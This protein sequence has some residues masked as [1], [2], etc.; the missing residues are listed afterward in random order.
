MKVLTKIIKWLA[1]TI[2][3]ILLLVAAVIGIAVWILTPERL[4]PLVE[5][6]ASEYLDAEVAVKRVELTYWSSFPKLTV[7][8]DS[9]VIVSHVF[10]RLTPAQ[11]DSLPDDADKLLSLAGL[12]GSVDL[13]SLMKGMLELRDIELQHPEIRLI[14][15]DKSLS[16][17]MIVK[18]GD[19]SDSSGPMPAI[20]IN[21]FRITGDSPISYF[22]LS[23][24]IDVTIKL[25][26]TD[27]NGEDAPVYSIQVD[28][29]GTGKIANLVHM[30]GIPFGLNG[31]VRWDMADPDRL[32]ISDFDFSADNI[33]VR[34]NGQID[35]SDSLA[36]TGLEIYGS[37]VKI[38]NLLSLARKT[39]L[40]GIPEI[41]TNLE[42]ELRATLG[43]PYYFGSDS[44]PDIHAEIRIPEGY[45]HYD[46]LRINRFAAD[47]TADI[48]RGDPDHARIEI[49]KLK[50]VGR[51]MGFNLS[52][53]VTSTGDISNPLV[54]GR[55]EGGLGFGRIPRKLADRLPCTLAGY[56]TGDT[57]FRFRPSDLRNV[58]LNAIKLDGTV[59]LHDF[60]MTMRDSSAT[61]FVSNAKLSFGAN[62]RLRRE[63]FVIDSL[64]TAS[65]QVDSADYTSGG[66]NFNGRDLFIGVGARHS[67]NRRLSG[68]TTRILPVGM[69][70]SGKRLTM[71]DT[72]D[73]LRIRLRD[74]DSRLTLTRFEGNAH[75][76]KLSVDIGARRLFY[77]DR[78]NRA[79]LRNAEV[80]LL[81]HP[82]KRPRL[83][84]RGIAIYDS[85]QSAKP[86]LRLDSVYALTRAEMRRQRR[87]RRAAESLSDSTAR[88]D[89]LR[90]RRSD[91]EANHSGDIDFE[92]DN[93][94]K[95]WLRLW[96]ASGNLKAERARAFTPYF[97]IRNRLDNVDIT[98]DTDSIKITDTRYRSGKTSVVVNGHI[99]NI[100]GAVTSRRGAPLDIDVSLDFDTLDINAFATAAFAGT[101]FA[102]RA[103]SGHVAI[104][105]SENDEELQRSISEAAPDTGQLAFVVPSNIKGNLRLNAREVLYSDIWF[106]RVNGNIGISNGSIHLDR[107]AGYTEMGT[108]DLTALYTAP[109]RRDVNFAAG[110]VIRRLDLKKFLH[111]MPQVDSLLPL[112][113]HIEGIIT[114]DMGMTT[115]LDS[116]MNFKFHTLRAVMKLEGDSLVVLDNS[117]F[118]KLSKWLI[119]KNKDRNMID[120]MAVELVVRD[121]KLDFMPFQFDIDRY[122]LGVWGGN[123]LDMHYDYH[124]AVLKSPLPFK[125]GIGIK[126]HGDDF[127]IRLGKANFNP[128]K[129]VESRQLT[130]TTRINLIRE[131]RSMFR[132]GV[133][134]GSR[135]RKLA[136]Q[137]QGPVN[138][139]DE[140]S[141]P[142]TLTHADSVLF[143]QQGIIEMSPAVADSIASTVDKNKTKTKKDKKKK[144]KNDKR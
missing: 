141:V 133:N 81:L 82:R 101:A 129:I 127:R 103:D 140:F 36:V 106:Q 52:A 23:D 61:A 87:Q 57:R 50:A 54:E 24:S 60:A 4:T 69:R 85:I 139:P 7:E 117:T 104:S 53:T 126:G 43:S 40:K 28:G 119:F 12:R 99:A 63:K 6:Y 125:F 144:R 128:D 84:E 77:A 8:V 34:F 130:D 5:H 96:Q 79:N 18:G 16:N 112:L 42:V 64:A 31:N 135:N 91:Y 110:M 124:I 72:S 9:L 37:S 35:F 92:V 132:F 25:I 20:S 120:H 118:R 58:D 29:I 98:F 1:I 15:F 102:E 2:L 142:D 114:A 89:S 51:S 17:Y 108:L 44:I 33:T 11:R 116:L 56:M 75:R 26:T 121:S 48:Q 107:F 95:T 76:P 97:P 134:S 38:D 59:N 86:S 109:N 22:S 71:A 136:L 14:E 46:R 143:M 138:Q 93:S 122:K 65:L 41:D 105:Q 100:A 90:K 32:G 123:T 47:I 88:A 49:R 13:P 94:M 74:L 55:F 115:E 21:S 19:D 39:S 45:L 131:I 62:S 137:P 27:L 80:S 113:D 67:D 66:V 70:I 73:S 68:D 30:Q 10:D 111:M 83:S 3:S 78:L